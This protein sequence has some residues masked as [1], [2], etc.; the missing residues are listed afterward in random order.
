M[1]EA[2]TFYRSDTGDYCIANGDEAWAFTHENR[3]VKR[4]GKLST[5]LDSYFESDLSGERWYPFTY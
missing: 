1:R 5:L 2:L 3:K 4:V